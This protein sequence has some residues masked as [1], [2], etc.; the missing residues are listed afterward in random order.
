[1]PD[2]LSSA[3]PD[4]RSPRTPC[5]LCGL[6]T[7]RTDFP[8]DFFGK[9]LRFCCPGCRGVYQILANDPGQ[10]ANFRETALYRAC[11]ESGIIPRTAADSETPKPVAEMPPGE[12]LATALPLTLRIEG[13]WCPA[14]AWLIEEV[15]RRPRGISEAKIQFF[16]DLAHIRYYPSLLT[17]KEIIAK[18]SGLGYRASLF[19]GEE[20][21]TPEKRSLLIR[22]GV[23]SILTFNIM[24]MAFALYL[25]FFEDLTAAGIRLLSWPLWAMATPVVFYGGWPILRRGLSSLRHGSPTM[26]ALISIGALSAYAYSFFQMLRGSLHLY[27]DTAAMI[28]TL[29]LVGKYI[30]LQARQKVSKGIVE[31]YELSSRKVRFSPPSSSPPPP[32]LAPREERT[33]AGTIPA[34]APLSRNEAQVAEGGE[35]WIP[36]NEVKAG[37]L[38]FVS[39]G[40]RIPLDARIVS[41]KGHVDESFLTGESRPVRKGP[42]DEVPGGALLVDGDLSLQTTRTGKEGSLSQMIDLMQEALTRKNPAEVLA[43]R[44]TRWFVPAVFFIALAAGFYLWAAGIPGE[45]A[46][47]RSLT[48]LVISCPCALGIAAPIA[49]VAAVGVGRRRGILV[50]DPAAFER[51]NKIDTWIFDKTGTLT[52]GNFD[53]L[54]ILLEEGDEKE[55]LGTLAA[56]EISSSH[57]LAKAIVRNARE[58]GVKLETAPDFREIEGLGVEACVAGKRVGIGNQRLMIRERMHI[59]SPLSEKAAF[60]EAAGN[61]VVFFGWEEKSRGLAVFGDRLRPGVRE[62]IQSLHVKGI[63]TWLVSGDAAETTRAIALEAEIKNHRGQASP[64]DKVELIRELQAKNRC[65][66]M[67]GDGF[68]D[69][70]A[71]AQADVGVALGSGANLAREASDLTFLTSDPTRILDAR[72]LSFSTS[73]IIRQNLLFAFAY[74]GLALPAAVSGLLNPLIAV[75]AMFAGSLTVIG[76]AL[77]I[78]KTDALH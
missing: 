54:R 66:G 22:L 24:M 40:E 44:I 1:M 65:V 21:Q 70:A 53:L 41:G 43:D 46:L 23:S 35:R 34:T 31:L 10:S 33:G 74:N 67:V 58:A 19:P 2:T 56:V 7:G 26:E 64:T 51:V 71:L 75:F 28:I 55:T 61:T 72:T 3:S 17:P 48:V 32:S 37:D 49:K 59:P 60:F 6:P 77:R 76:N 27:F 13:M 42:G 78:S 29:V 5:D 25:G 62:M 69:A 68:N 4:P 50:R 63:E 73:K 45:E 9:D 30:E 36:A 18:I 20:G 11:V 14:C 47:L 39:A 8:L 52:E 12:S 15:L 57:F 16:S 38:F